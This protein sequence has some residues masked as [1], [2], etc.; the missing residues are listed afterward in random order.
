[1]YNSCVYFDIL[2]TSIKAIRKG[3]IMQPN[4]E[5]Y[6]V[7]HMDAPQS[8]PTSVPATDPVTS[9]TMT[10]EP[11]A[12]VLESYSEPDVSLPSQPVTYQPPMTDAQPQPVPMT[13]VMP[14]QPAPS[15]FFGKIK[16]FFT[17]K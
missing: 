15:G 11:V 5:S 14:A 4:D 10:P 8:A 2:E 12:P 6:P 1:M 13:P 9:P 7:N 16:S 3:D 17:K